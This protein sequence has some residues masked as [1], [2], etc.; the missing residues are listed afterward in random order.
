MTPGAP[1]Q[2]GVVFVGAGRGLR[3]V[4]GGASFQ[5]VFEPGVVDILEAFAG[6]PRNPGTVYAATLYQRF[7]STDFG[8]TWA[9]LDEDPEHFPP[10]V[11]DLVVA[12][13]DPQTL[14]ETGDGAN[15][16]ATWRSHE[17]AVPP[18]RARSSSAA[19]C[20]RSIRWTPIRSMA[21]A[22]AA[23]S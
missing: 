9:P 5:P 22:S 10:F 23:S 6:H 17:A 16:G 20:S 15:V 19:T 11:H 1:G 3:S 18:G 14:Y 8:A 13:G 4:D 7:K 12:P 21:A 2:P